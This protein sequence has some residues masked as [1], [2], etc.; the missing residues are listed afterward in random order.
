MFDFRRIAGGEPPGES[1]GESLEEIPNIIRKDKNPLIARFN[2]LND[3]VQIIV[4][5]VLGFIGLFVGTWLL[6]PF[7]ETFTNAHCGVRVLLG[8]A[9]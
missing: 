8:M 1:Q 6:S 4:I 5:L 2:E 3:F 9:C 7:S